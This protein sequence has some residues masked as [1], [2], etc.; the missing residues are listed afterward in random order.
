M[1]NRT[2]R[3]VYLVTYSQADKLKFPSRQH[4]G[5]A[6]EE[7]LNSG[8]SKV[9]ATY[10]ACCL[11]NHQ[12]GGEHFHVSIKLTGPKRWLP[13][14]K[15]LSEHYGISVHFSDNHDSYYSAYQYVSKSDTSVF[16]SREHPMLVPQKLKEVFR[17]TEI[18]EKAAHKT[19]HRQ[20]HTISN[21][22]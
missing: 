4:F 3:R 6:V 19:D 16:H 5:K 7:A 11:E 13:A 1:N 10:W 22:D 15:Y 12:D 17:P 2:L 8:T 18:S 9:K 20:P 21:K 14:K